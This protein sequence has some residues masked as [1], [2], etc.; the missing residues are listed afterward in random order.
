PCSV[1]NGG[2]HDHCQVELGRV[3]CSCRRG[4]TLADDQISCTDVD[5]CQMPGSCSH[6]CRNTWGSY[7]C[8]CNAGYQ[9][10]TD[11][12]SCYMIDMEVINSCLE[13]NGGCQHM[14]RHGPGGPVCTCHPGYLLQLDRHTCKDEDECEAKTHRCQQECVNTAGGYACACALGYTLS[15]DTFTCVDVDE[16]ELEN[17]GCEHQCHNTR[18]SYMCSCHW[19]YVLVDHTRC[20]MVE[21]QY[22]PQDTL[23]DLDSATITEDSEVVLDTAA[24]DADLPED[25]TYAEYAKITTLQTRCV[26]GYFGFNCTLTCDDCPGQCDASGCVCPAGTTG[27]TCSLTCPSGTYGPDCNQVCR[28]ENGGTCHPVSGNCSCPPGVSGELCEDGC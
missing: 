14:C 10:G 19:G 1:D 23:G 28:C 22:T 26:P 4:F 2:C 9:L 11:H 3:R 17:G 25:V 15:S 7:E 13:N 21:G 16:C 5:E 18:G 27:P 8:F 20:D 12:K 6:Q 24:S